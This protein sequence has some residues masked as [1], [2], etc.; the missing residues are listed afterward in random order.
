MY[1][2][3]QILIWLGIVLGILSIVNIVTG[4]LINVW[5]KKEEFSLNKMIKGILKVLV[6]YL[7]ASALAI[8]FGLL[9]NINQ[10]ITTTFNVELLSNE[11]LNSLSSVG[12]LGIVISTIM[13]QGE[14]AIK[15]IIE[16]SKI[17][18]RVD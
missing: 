9:P 11:L 17:S 5:D 7:G 3:I 16:L 13:T 10:M 15:G 14:K 2:L 6:F 12:V 8:A 18:F 4:T 1:N